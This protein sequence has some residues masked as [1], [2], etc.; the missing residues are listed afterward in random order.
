MANVSHVKAIIHGKY[1]DALLAGEEWMFGVD[2]CPIIGATFEDIWTVT[3]NFD[4]VYTPSTGSGTGWIGESNVLLEGGNDDIDLL[5][6]LESHV[7]PSAIAYLNT[8]GMFCA[9]VYIDQIEAWP[10]GQDGKVCQ[11]EVGAAY[12]TITATVTTWDGAS[13]GSPSLAPFTSFAV[14]KETIANVPRGRG[15]FYPPHN[16]AIAPNIDTTGL[17]SAT[18]RTTYA[19]AAKAYLE[20]IQK[21]AALG[22]TSMWPVVIGAPFTTAYKITGVSV[23]NIPDTQRR[24]KYS[25]GSVR[26]NAALAF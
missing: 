5:D 12:A 20:G 18:G 8:T 1:K 17:L 25:L 10:Y 11:L 21:D 19:N 3:P 23:D 13:A 14:T 6:W 24:R 16:A 26:T 2:L 4:A 7:M 15:R 9:D 22:D